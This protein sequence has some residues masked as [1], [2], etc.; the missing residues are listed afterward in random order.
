MLDTSMPK[1]SDTTPSE[2][3][4]GTEA[5]DRTNQHHPQNSLSQAKLVGDNFS[6]L[7][8]RDRSS[9]VDAAVVFLVDQFPFNLVST[10]YSLVFVRDNERSIMQSQ[11]E[12]I[13][14]AWGILCYCRMGV[15][16]SK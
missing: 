3:R 5:K 4:K 10:F 16:S 2:S 13:I 15:T 14:Y 9:E 11:D 7:F 12:F 1:G 6:D 8:V